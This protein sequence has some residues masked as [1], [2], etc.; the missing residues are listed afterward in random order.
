MKDELLELAKQYRENWRDLRDL[1]TYVWVCVGEPEQ[2]FAHLAFGNIGGIAIEDAERDARENPFCADANLPADAITVL[3]TL[4]FEAGN[5]EPG[6]GA[7]YF[8]PVRPLVLE[9]AP[10]EWKAEGWI[11]SIEED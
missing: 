2:P 11:N 9:L 5:G 6:E 8:E 1:P 4:E 3:C 10:E 7:W